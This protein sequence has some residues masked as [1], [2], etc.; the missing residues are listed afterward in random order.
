RNGGAGGGGGRGR[1]G[2]GSVR[3]RHGGTVGRVYRVAGARADRQ[4]DGLRA[5]HQ[6]IAERRNRARR[7]GK[8][9]GNLD[10]SGDGRVIGAVGCRATDRV[11]DRQ[12]EGRVTDAREGEGARVGAHLRGG[13]VG[14]GDAHH[15]RRLIGDRHRVGAGRAHHVAGIR[16]DRQD[17]GLGVFHERIVERRDRARRGGEAGGNLDARGDNRVVRTV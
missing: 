10:A 3:Y 4:D 17:D 15:R 6:R 14:G 2:R 7:G 8:A 5:F 16:T 1:R 13:G 12:R 9:G 11:R